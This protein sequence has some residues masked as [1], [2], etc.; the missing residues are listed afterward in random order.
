[1]PNCGRSTLRGQFSPPSALWL[2]WLSVTAE[3]EWTLAR[4]AERGLANQ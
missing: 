2:P 1:M 3:Y 4:F